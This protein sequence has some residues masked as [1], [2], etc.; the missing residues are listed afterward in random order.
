MLP[1]VKVAPLDMWT[2]LLS[3]IRYSMGRSSYIT[4]TA[5]KLVIQYA[6]AL[7]ASQLEQIAREIEEEIAVYEKNG[8]TLGMQMDHDGWIR[9]AARIRL[10]AEKAALEESE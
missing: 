6:S 1:E 7:R 3:T 10:L 9:S 8:R 2:L 5:P 4:D